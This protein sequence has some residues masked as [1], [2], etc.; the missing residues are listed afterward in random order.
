[1]DIYLYP[2]GA[3]SRALIK[4][5]KLFNQKGNSARAFSRGKRLPVPALSTVGL[6]HLE[7]SRVTETI[8]P[9][10]A[11]PPPPTTNAPPASTTRRRSHLNKKT[12]IKV[13]CLISKN[14]IQLVYSDLYIYIFFGDF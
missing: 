2:G 8:P 11:S 14:N 1:M 3:Q 10:S 5:G 12:I 9:I 4:E 6:W 7:L 13:N